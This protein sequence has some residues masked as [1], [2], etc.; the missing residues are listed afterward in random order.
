MSGFFPTSGCGCCGV[1]RRKF[2]GHGCGAC[3]AA[4]ALAAPRSLWAAGPAK[5]RLRL[6]FALHADVQARPDWPNIGFDFQPVMQRFQSE[7][8]QRCPQFEFVTSTATG[9]EQAQALVKADAAANV[10]GYVVVQLNC[11]NRVVQT[12]ATTNKPVLYVDFQYGGSGGHLVYTAGFLR[13]KAPNVGFVASSKIDDLAAAVKCF[14]LIAQGRSPAEFVAATAQVRT[15]HT[16][17]AAK[18]ALAADSVQTL[19][20]KECLERMKQ[21]K[22]LALRNT[23]SGEAPPLLGI[24]VV[25]VSFAELNDL[26]KAADREAVTQIADRW[27]ASA[28]AIE[29]VNRATLIDS[30]AM[31]LA[32]KA[33][34]KKYNAN[35]ISINCLGGFYGGHI[36]AYPCLGFHELNNEG[37]IG[38]C[39]CDLRSA[40]TMVAMNILTQ[41]RPGYI[42]DPVIDTAKRQ[43]I[44]A[45]CV[46]SNKPFGPTGPTNKFQI[47]THSEDRQGAA[48]RSLFPLGH[49]VTTVEFF[50]QKK[51]VLFHQ[52]IAVE[53]VIDDRACRTKLAAE[54]CGDI[55]KLF[56]QWDQWGWH[57]VT[58]FGDLK[59]PVFALA[60]ALGFEVVQEA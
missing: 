18:H 36:H 42:S 11:W 26:W 8:A 27:Q 14:D 38:G 60:D 17:A 28:A 53:N 3:A 25:R 59:E 44:Y 16:P 47:L 7:L 39:E 54:P 15:S 49:K 37:L 55:E 50:S 20:P 40:S 52:G 29:N 22:I 57:R 23:E 32:E 1:S 56:T 51:Q 12:I 43:V 31:Y 30:A 46:A 24:P 4:T 13:N 5:L 34:L 48:V 9:P 2:L 58:V 10:D 33:L 35:A 45:H 19:A 6:V 41:G 21:S